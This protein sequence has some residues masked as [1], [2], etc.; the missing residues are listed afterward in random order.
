[1]RDP[2]DFVIV[3][4]PTATMYCGSHAAGHI[5][6]ILLV[7][8]DN[9]IQWA[10]A[11]ES[12]EDFDPW[13]EAVVLIDVRHRVLALYGELGMSW[14][15]GVLTPSTF[16]LQYA[17]R[18]AYYALLAQAWPGWELQWAYEGMDDIVRYL[19]D[20]Y[21]GD[22]YGPGP[23][24]SEPWYDRSPVYVDP[25]SDNPGD[26][27]LVTHAVEP[28]APLRAYH[29][30]NDE[31]SAFG[32]G[33][34][35]ATALPPT[36]LVTELPYPP[37][38]GLHLDL[39]ARHAMVW[40]IRELAGL[41]SDWPRLWPGWQLEFHNDR[42][43]T[44]LARCDGR[45]F[46]L[47]PDMASAWDHLTRW[48]TPGMTATARSQVRHTPRW[49]ALVCPPRRDGRRRAAPRQHSRDA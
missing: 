15:E 26:S 21:R 28:G 2:A 36:G 41:R 38:S 3:D 24:L 16:E 37:T 27:L 49:P 45:L 48:A 4:G 39:G 43:E 33:A 42:Y 44:Q 25:E 13:C 40:T 18:A 19:G 11:E 29:L 14:F 31:N 35:L 7:G 10:R 12:V 34:T 32:I 47:E 46:I 1:M 6:Q 17:Y 23:T 22:N 8:P 9:T 20:R 5:G 30:Y